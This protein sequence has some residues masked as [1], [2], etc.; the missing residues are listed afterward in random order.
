[1]SE[2]KK[3]GALKILLIIVLA[4]VVIAGGIFAG[5]KFAMKSAPKTTTI[6]VQNLNKLTYGLGEFV[7][8]LADT[9]SDRYLKV[10]I[11]LEY[12]DEKFKEELDKSNTQIRDAVN[13][14]LMS[15]KVTDIKA[16]NLN[17]LKK[18]ILDKINPILTTNQVTNIY[19]DDIIVQ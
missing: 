7:I 15:K 4:L 5:Y 10:K 6:K 17:K 18:D 3:G 11:S 14:L 12:N 2:N 19:F 1:M 8:K 9:D 16:Q 13:T